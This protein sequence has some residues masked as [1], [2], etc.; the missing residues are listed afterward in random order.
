MCAEERMEGKK[1][2]K[3]NKFHWEVRK[4]IGGHTIHI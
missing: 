4:V 2:K 3:M 1:L